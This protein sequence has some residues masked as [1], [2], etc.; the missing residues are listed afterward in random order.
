MNDVKSCVGGASRDIL[1]GHEAVLNNKLITVPGLLSLLSLQA[2]LGHFYAW[3]DLGDNLFMEK[4][5][6]LKLSRD[7]GSLS[8]RL[9][10]TM[11][12]MGPTYNIFGCN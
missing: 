12:L 4:F 11:I 2:A 10:T 1:R 5:T 8:T 6:P 3:P 9:Y 7:T